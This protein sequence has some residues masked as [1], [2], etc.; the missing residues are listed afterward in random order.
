MHH[1]IQIYLN[2]LS[3]LMYI[4][5]YTMVQLR[6]TT[7]LLA[8]KVPVHMHNLFMIKDLIHELSQWK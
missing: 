7:N 2:S 4:H 1:T 8:L 6:L 5:A 3:K